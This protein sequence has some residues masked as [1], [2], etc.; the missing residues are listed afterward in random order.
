MGSDRI[1]H[2]SSLSILVRKRFI[3]I[4]DVSCLHTL[5]NIQRKAAMAGSEQIPRKSDGLS[6]SLR[7]ISPLLSMFRLGHHNEK[8]EREI[9]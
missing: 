3:K 8:R 9:R 2:G 7:R 4:N 5:R 1:L 6:L